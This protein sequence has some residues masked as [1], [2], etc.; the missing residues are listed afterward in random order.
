[1]IWVILGSTF[2]KGKLTLYLRTGVDK[3][4]SGGVKSSNFNFCKHKLPTPPW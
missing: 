3:I 2:W 4:C 1:V